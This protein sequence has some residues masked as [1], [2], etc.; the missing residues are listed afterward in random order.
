MA[1]V[2]VIGGGFGGLS[3]AITLQDEGH[4]VVVLEARDRVGGRVHTVDDVVPGRLI[5]AGGELI[6]RNHATWLAYARRLG[7]GLSLISDDDDYAEMGLSA[8]LVLDGKVISEDDADAMWEAVEAAQEKL[9]ALAEAAVPDPEAPWEAP[10]AARL[11]GLSVGTWLDENVPDPLARRYFEVS[12]YGEYGCE[13]A[14]Q[15]LLGMLASVAGQPDVWED[16]EVFRCADGNQ[17][18]AEG[19]AAE[20]PVRLSAPADRITVTAAGVTVSSG[21]AVLEADFVVLAIPPSVWDRVTIEPPLPA[22]YRM[23]MGTV[24]K[25]LSHLDG[26]IW[27]REGIGPV[28]LDESIGSTW[29]STDQQQGPGR[30][31]LAV[32]AGGPTAAPALRAEDVDAYYAPHLERLFPGYAAHL[33]GTRFVPWPQEPWTGAGYSAPAPGDIVGAMRLLCTA[34]WQGRLFFA[35]E[36]ADPRFFGFMEGALRSGQ[37]AAHQI[38]GV[39]R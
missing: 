30:I 19:L 17:A 1:R 34:P 2:V 36:H 22:S 6:G 9:S 8:P 27:I 15:S 39:S 14:A 26:R 29:E 20:V 21:E 33:Q 11:D 28:G 12:F 24:L 35:G 23:Q 5:E 38:H 32:F 4:E 16:Y 18:L 13:T 7:L 31:G 25:Y 37:R 10:E 3:A